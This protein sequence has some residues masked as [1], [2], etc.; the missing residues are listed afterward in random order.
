MIH[1]SAKLCSMHRVINEF[2]VMTLPGGKQNTSS[3]LICLESHLEEYSLS[4]NINFSNIISFHCRNLPLP[5][6]PST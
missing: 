2:I 3:L 4:V 5:P 6:S 1:E